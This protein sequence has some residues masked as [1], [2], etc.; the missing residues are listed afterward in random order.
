MDN[1]L[2]ITC[3]ITGAETT[4][5][6]N[7]ALPITPEEIAQGA[8]EAWEAGASILHLHVRQDDGTPTQDVAVFKK[9]IDLIRANCD[10]VIE[11]TTGGAAWMT[12]EERL[13]PVTL[14]PEMASLD[15]GT[16]NFGDEYIVNTLPIMRQFA[17]AMLDHGV[18]PTLECFDLG[19]VYASHIL[20]KEGLLQE[21]YHYGLVLNVP[22]AAK[23]E[24]DVMEFLVRKLPKGAFFTAF[25]IGGKANVDSIYATIALGGHVRVGF[26]D[27]IYYSKGRLATS[28]AELVARAARIAKDCGRELARPDDVRQMLKLRQA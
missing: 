20:I 22:G 8:F 15:C 13:Q 23:Y 28:N 4:K 1:K 24:P 7:P 3:A 9:A 10:I 18:R 25:G 19:H 26:E 2:I 17:Q 16:V 11:T 12:P 6:M 14:N 27:N 21:P 5:E